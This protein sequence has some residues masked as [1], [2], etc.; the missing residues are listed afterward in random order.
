MTCHIAQHVSALSAAMVLLVGC[1]KVGPPVP[2]EYV[3]V[4]P[5]VERQRLKA[6]QAKKAKEQ[7]PTFTAEEARQDQAPTVEGV[8]LPPVYPGGTP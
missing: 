4:G 5:L 6:E 1:G 2:P 3:G 7:A 8:Q